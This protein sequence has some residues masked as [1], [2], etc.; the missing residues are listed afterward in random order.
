MTFTPL[1]TGKLPATH[2]VSDPL[3]TEYRD[4]GLAITPPAVFGHGNSFTDWGMNGNDNYG[5]CVLAGGGHEIELIANLAAGGVTNRKVVTVTAAN[6][7]ADYGAITGFDPATGAND[8]GTNVH[9]ALDYRIKT[10][11]I[12]STGKRHKIVAYVSLEVG[13]LAHLRQALWIFEAVGIGFE[14]PGTAQQQFAEGKVWS[15]VPGNPEIEGGHYVPLVGVPAVGN[16]ACV[17]WA[18]RQVMTDGFYEK[19][20]DEAYAYITEDELNRKSHRN[21]GGF[22]WADLKADLKLV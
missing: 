12:D 5:D 7:L 20:A 22:N 2:R 8:N 16:L 19:Y 21:W 15:V 13:N 11:L 17:S 18:R 9:E 4:A 1:P 10:G 6:S 14:V 3:F